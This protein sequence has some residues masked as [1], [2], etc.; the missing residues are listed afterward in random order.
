[1]ATNAF[2]SATT[3]AIRS[4]FEE[5][6]VAGPIRVVSPVAADEAIFV[7][8]THEAAQM[9]ERAVTEALIRLLRRKVWVATDGPE[10]L[11]NTS[12]LE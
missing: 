1:M 4:I 7:V 10:W 11:T 2:D 6:G 12:P 9:S 8:S 5:H 3:A